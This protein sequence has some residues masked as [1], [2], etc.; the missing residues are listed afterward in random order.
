MTFVDGDFVKIEYS[1][2]R[3]A[4][5]ALLST[6]NEQ[7]A[8]ENGTYDEKAKYR[9]QLVVIGKHDV[10]KGVENAIRNMSPNEEKKIDIEPKDAFGERDPSL[11]K[12]VALSD[13]RKRDIEPYPGMHIDVDGTEAV[14]KS[15]NSGRVV[16]DENN[17][18]A[19]EKLTYSLKVVE[20]IDKDEDKIKAIAERLDLEPKAVKLDGATAH[21]E[22]GDTSKN[23]DYEARKSMLPSYIFAYMQNINKVEIT[24]TYVREAQ[25]Q[26]SQQQKQQKQS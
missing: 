11:V 25:T 21:V 26:S 18:L 14:V 6:T 8:K 1:A 9:P 22:L 5:N 12:V 24:D 19:G 23:A 20:K 15:V 13:F 16:I 7:L 3:T 10:I 17:E 4:D 2:W